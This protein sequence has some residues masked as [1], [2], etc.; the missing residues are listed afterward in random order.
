MVIADNVLSA[1]NTGIGVSVADNAGAVAISGNS[2]AAIDH[3]IVG[4][5]WE[6]VVSD[7]LLRDAAKYPHVSLMGNRVA[8]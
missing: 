8:R 4:M 2:I 6:T 1:V 7:D 5:E 3:G